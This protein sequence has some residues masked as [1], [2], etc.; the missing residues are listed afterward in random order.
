MPVL[1]NEPHYEL[2]WSRKNEASDVD[3]RPWNASDVRVGSWQTAFSGAAGITYGDDNVMQMYIPE[4]FDPALS[5]VVK[6]WSESIASPGSAMMQYIKQ[7][8]LDRGKASFD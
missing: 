3:K 6:P 5:G 2:R 4:L 1:D 7:A 8:V